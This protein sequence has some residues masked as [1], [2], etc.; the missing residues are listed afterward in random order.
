MAHENKSTGMVIDG[1]AS[2]DGHVDSSG[3]I[4]ELDGADIS[5]LEEGKGLFCYEHKGAD[6][7][8]NDESYGQEIVGKIITGKK[9]YSRDD[10][11]NDRHRLF[12]DAIKTPYLY[13][14]GRLFDGAG[15]EGAKALAAA[16]R[17]A[18]DNDEDAILSYSVEGSV[19]KRDGNKLKKTIVR[20]VAL[21]WTPCLKTTTLG[22]VYDPQ[23]PTIVTKHEDPNF[24]RLG[25]WTSTYSPALLK[26]MVAGNTGSAAPSTYTQGAALQREDPGP[27]AKAIQLFHKWDRKGSFRDYL[28][29]EMD[30]VSDEFLDH[31][32]D[33]IDRHYVKLRKAQEALESAKEL[34]KEP[35][36]KK[37]KKPSMSIQGKRLRPRRNAPRSAIVK[38]DEL[39][40]KVGVFPLS[41]PT[42]PSQLLI[43]ATGKSPEEIAS[44]FD[45][46]MDKQRPSHQAAM[47]NWMRLNQD[48]REGRVNPD[49]AAHAIVFSLLSPG[50]PVP[51]Q[52]LMFSS[53]MDALKAHGD[54]ATS[55]ENFKDVAATWK[56]LG[57]EHT[58]PTH[59]SDHLRAVEHLLRAG[60]KSKNPGRLM[61]HMKPN[62]FLR[63]AGNYFDKHHQQVL[64]ILSK[65][66]GDSRPLLDYLV[67]I[68]GIKE[69]LARYTAGMMG[70]GD[71]TVPDTHF[72]KHIFGMRPD[73]EGEQAGVNP[74]GPAINYLKNHLLSAANSA[75]VMR[76]V[77][78]WYLKNH[79][80]V[81]KV[82][83][84]PELG[85]RFRD[86]PRNA[87]FPA[88]WWHWN[89]IGGHYAALGQPQARV[90]NAGTTH[91][92][93]W[94]AVM[95]L[96]RSET[97]DP[98]MPVY[99]AM[100]H[101][102]WLERYGP[103]KAL[104]LYTRFLVPKLVA[105]YLA[106]KDVLVRKMESL[107]VELLSTLRK[108]AKAPTAPEPGRATQANP[109]DAPLILNHKEHGVGTY[110]YKPE[111]Q[112]MINGMDLH[113]PDNVETKGSRPNKRWMHNAHGEK[114][115]VK[116]PTDDDQKWQYRDDHITEA[117]RE[118]IYSNLA[119]DYFGL[120]KYVPHVGVVNDPTD[121]YDYAIIEHKPGQHVDLRSKSRYDAEHHAIIDNM[122]K[123]GD[124]D[125]IA[126]MD[127]IMGNGDRHSENFLVDNKANQ[128]HLIDHGLTLEHQW[129]STMWTPLDVLVHGDRLSGS[130]RNARAESMHPDA[131][132]WALG[133][134]ANELESNLAMHEV[135]ATQIG[136]AGERLRHIQRVFKH[137]ITDR[138]S[139][140]SIPGHLAPENMNVAHP[141]LDLP[142]DARPTLPPPSGYPE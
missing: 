95:P 41:S 4:L 108:A 141:S 30:D 85:P 44:S 118:G 96:L 102:R 107:Q 9:I 132:Q 11:E 36:K 99:T 66:G 10:C 83:N 47:A 114:V 71:V 60:P 101:H 38:D 49:V 117:R 126:L 15:H 48:Y 138:R 109:A 13:V 111:V 122:A 55:G 140:L 136:W 78:D 75:Q 135:P 104:E 8:D 94:D 77:D 6:K 17:D 40:T 26:T 34:P 116:G 84:D 137:G 31:F 74:D 43:Q 115:L 63:F 80:A 3:E 22:M 124:M 130:G 106:K 119:H 58:W 27:K 129:K 133:L 88:F 28:K 52:E 12:W 57:K 42:K 67:K 110:N 131:I 64:D 142:Q 98:E 72:I 69:K 51:N 25:G 89:S 37:A 32:T 54:E 86:S 87:L 134:D 20:R 7:N 91:G 79:P 113:G 62:Q 73:M 70:A 103:M 112:K 61:G 82:L 120:G 68:P 35:Q 76:G 53:W 39:H 59:G 14:I 5:S 33:I 18:A 93:Y 2:V 50:T 123:S 21:T 56:R 46:E 125:K 16:V 139:I 127:L 19:L 97:Y 90:F 23:R 121:G 29:A 81:Q 92:P 105:N 128:I 24:M 65:S 45:A 100:Q 1:I